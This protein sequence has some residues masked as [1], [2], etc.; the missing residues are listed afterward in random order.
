[1]RLI[2]TSKSWWLGKDVHTWKVDDGKYQFDITDPTEQRK[3]WFLIDENDN[4]I[5]IANAYL[6]DQLVDAKKKDVSQ[7]AKSLLV[8]FRFLK[9]N[10][11]EWN[12]TTPEVERSYRPIFQFRAK[13]KQLVEHGIYED[14]TAAGYLS[15]IRSF[16]T[17]CYRHR[18]LEQ[19]PF[20]ITGK[21]RYGNDITDCSISI[22]SRTRRLRPLSE[23][24]LKLLFQS[25]H[26]VAPEIR[27]CILMSLFIGLRETEV[28]SIPKRLFKVPKGFKGRNVPDITVGPKTRVRTKGSVE[29][30]IPFPVWLINLVNKY[31]KTERYKKRAEDYK[32]M[33]DCSDDQVPAILNRDG[34]PYSTATLTSLWGKITKEIRKIDPHYRHKWHDCRCTYGCGTMDAY[35]AVNGLDRNMALSQLKKNMGHSRSTTTLL[36]LEFWDNDPHTTIIA[37]VMGDFVEM[38]IESIGV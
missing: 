35:L 25:W 38:I 15:H 16:Y 34:E 6:L 5:F 19:L 27:L 23:Y 37:D 30:Q 8:F 10:D 36:Y 32:L 17:F 4:P 14:T 12:M 20:N 26:V 31:H 33:Y 18:Y 29:R 7:K 13:L 3:C 21:T 2:S 28:S 11:L 24:H 9:T 1:M 22:R